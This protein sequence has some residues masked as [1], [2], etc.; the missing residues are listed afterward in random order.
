VTCAYF[1]GIGVKARQ[2]CRRRDFG[3][4]CRE[5][6]E[7]DLWL[8]LLTQAAK[9]DGDRSSLNTFIDRM[10]N[11]AAAALVRSREREMRADGF[12]SQSLDAAPR[13]K[14]SLAGE[15]APMCHPGV[16]ATGVRDHLFF[17]VMSNSHRRQ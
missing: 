4:S 7:Q 14:E 1:N 5:D 9:F 10:V 6:I 16:F 2:L 8:H 12:R 17:P 11:S 15:V 13:G 3:R